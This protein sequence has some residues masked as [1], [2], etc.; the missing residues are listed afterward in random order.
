MFNGGGGEPQWVGNTK[1]MNVCVCACRCMCVEGEG[2]ALVSQRQKDGIEKCPFSYWLSQTPSWWLT[3]AVGEKTR[4]S[5]SWAICGI[6]FSNTCER[7]N[8]K[9]VY[10]GLMGKWF[11]KTCRSPVNFIPRPV[12]SGLVWEWGL[13][14]AGCFQEYNLVTIW[15]SDTSQKIFARMPNGSLCLSSIPCWA[16]VYVQNSSH[17]SSCYQNTQSYIEPAG[18][19]IVLVSFPGPLF[20]K[21][22]PGSVEARKRGRWS[23]SFPP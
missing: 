2:K 7:C 18:F 20:I 15:V 14:G 9:N 23:F 10:K 6:N 21:Q 1:E 4:P 13:L 5:F 8:S 12:Q 19:H 11:I 22:G 17:C 16:C 3:S